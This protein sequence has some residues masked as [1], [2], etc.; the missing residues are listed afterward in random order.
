[1]ETA[2]RSNHGFCARPGCAHTKAM[3][4][5]LASACA[6]YI[7]PG[8]KEANALKR[9]A[10]T[11]V[12]HEVIDSHLLDRVLMAGALEHLQAKIKAATWMLKMGLALSGTGDQ[13]AAQRSFKR[14]LLALGG[15]GAS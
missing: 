4:G 12:G 8:S 1:M 2:Q 9:E 5:R 3:H 14:A 11:A 7:Q 10:P 6:N 15:L 13:K